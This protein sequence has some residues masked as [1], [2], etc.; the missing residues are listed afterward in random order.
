MLQNIQLDLL[1]DQLIAIQ[2]AL[3]VA[4]EEVKEA[5]NAQNI[6]EVENIIDHKVAIHLTTIFQAR[7]LIILEEVEPFYF[8]HDQGLFT[9]LCC[10]KA[11][12]YFFSQNEEMARHY[13]RLAMSY[14]LQYEKYGTIAASM[15]NLLAMKEHGYS[16]DHYLNIAESIPIIYS[17]SATYNIETFCRRLLSVFTA[18]LEIGNIGKAMQ[19]LTYIESKNLYAEPERTWV[20]LQLFKGYIQQQRENYEEAMRYYSKVLEVSLAQFDYFELAQ[21]AY[22]RLHTIVNNQLANMPLVNE[23]ERF[24]SFKQQD[25][26]QIQQHAMQVEAAHY[27]SLIQQ[28]LTEESF[29][30]HALQL[31]QQA[32]HVGVTVVCI[33]SFEQDAV[34]N[35]D[36]LSIFSEQLQASIVYLKNANCLMLA[37]IDEDDSLQNRCEQIVN[38]IDSK[39]Y[40]SMSNSVNDK[41]QTIAHGMV[42]AHASIYYE[43][44]KG[45]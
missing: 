1:D 38:T 39:L 15:T 32:S 12:V 25:L 40:V 35:L 37:F 24:R 19:Y 16:P 43:L 18:Q 26:Q 31:Q 20:Q 30:Q 27:H 8:E 13:Y 33:E 5:M 42:L 45:A 28:S 21:D 23:F 22:E 34:H 17:Y 29:Q 36:A 44:N 7:V 2:Q 41:W 14:G 11:H 3:Q 4:H 10:L 9:E 6:K